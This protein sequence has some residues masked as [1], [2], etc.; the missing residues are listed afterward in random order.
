MFAGY[1]RRCIVGLWFTWAT[2]HYGEFE[3]D[4]INLEEIVL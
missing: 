3:K 1:L 4:E 2:A